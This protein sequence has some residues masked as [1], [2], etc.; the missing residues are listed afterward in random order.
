MV[1]SVCSLRITHLSSARY[2]RAAIAHP[3][4]FARCLRRGFDEVLALAGDP[5]P[6]VVPVS[7]PEQSEQSDEEQST[8]GSVA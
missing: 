8:N 2:D 4:L 6:R 3:E 7:S 1:P 5:A